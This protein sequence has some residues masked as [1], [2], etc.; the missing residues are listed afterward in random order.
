MSTQLLKKAR[1]DE[2]TMRKASKSNG[3]YNGPGKAH[4]EGI[5]LLELASMFPDENT[6]RE[7]FESLIWPND[8][9]CCTRCGGLDTYAVKN[10][11]MPYRCRDCRRYFSAKMGTA[12][13]GLE[14]QLPEVVF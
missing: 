10:Q 6:S 4:R 12:L 9:R 3:H 7:W 2:G 1:G 11:K 5:T 14:D 8:E 13:E